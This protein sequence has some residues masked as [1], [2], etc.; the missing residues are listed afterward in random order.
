MYPNYEIHFATTA[1]DE[2]TLKRLAQLD[3]QQPLTG[4]ALIGTLHGEPVAAIS[5]ADGR[6]TADPFEPTERLVQVLRMRRRS[7]DAATRTPQVTR[8]VRAAIGTVP[9]AQA[10]T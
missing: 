3:S 5:L 8:R 1:D 6:V 10:T 2:T 9:R 7:I 4:G